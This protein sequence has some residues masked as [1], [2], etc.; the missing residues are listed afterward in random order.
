MLHESNTYIWSFK[1]AVE[2]SASIEFRVFINADENIQW[3]YS[4]IQ[5]TNM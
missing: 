1:E 4:A 2:K 3:A 5:F